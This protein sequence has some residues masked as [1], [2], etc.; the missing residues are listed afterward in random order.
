MARVFAS[1]AAISRSGSSRQ[2]P[3]AVGSSAT[4]RASPPSTVTAS[5]MLGQ[6][7]DRIT[8]LSPGS[9]SACAMNMMPLI[10][11]EVTMTRSAATGLA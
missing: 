2:P 10:P 9:I 5:L 11:E 3:A 7:G 4:A 8:I 6:T 1:Q